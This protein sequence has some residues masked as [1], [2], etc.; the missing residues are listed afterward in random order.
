MKELSVY[1]CPS[2]GRYTFTRPMPSITCPI[3]ETSMELLTHYSNFCSLDQEERDKLLARKIIDAN[4]TACSRFLA[5]MRSCSGGEA[6]ALSDPYL[7]VLES[8]NKK[9][10]ETIQWMHQTIWDLLAKN[11][12]LEHTLEQYLAKS[13]ET[14]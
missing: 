4:P 5:Y 14:P 2:C 6:A 13:D 1:C 12:E 10:N 9:L 3:C 11:K 8:E 7:P